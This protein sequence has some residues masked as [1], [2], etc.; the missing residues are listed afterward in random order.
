MRDV[1]Q[2]T[3]HDLAGFHIQLPDNFITHKRPLAVTIF[4]NDNTKYGN[5]VQRKPLCPLGFPE[6]SLWVFRPCLLRRRRLS[7]R[8]G[9]GFLLCPLGFF[10]GFLVGQPG[11]PAFLDGP[12]VQRPVIRRLAFFFLFLAVLVGPFD[13]KP[14]GVC[15]P[16]APT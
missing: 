10:G 12:V 11:M 8:G 7:F 5:N 6:S 13:T 9:L 16:Y 4:G 2:A 1:D 15:N 3:F 14:V